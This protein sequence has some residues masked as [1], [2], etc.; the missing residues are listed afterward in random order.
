VA[1]TIPDHVEVLYELA[2]GAPVHMSF[3]ETTGLSRGN[4][5]WIFGSKGTIHVD[6]ANRIFVG[7]VGD[8]E[9]AEHPNPPEGQYRHRV[10]EEFI[11][12]IRG[13][14]PVS[15]NTFEIGVRY[16]EWTEAVHRSANQGA[17][18]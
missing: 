12:A 2:N 10:E 15:M 1:A 11:N 13:I 17:G 8:R 18:V 9:L 14:E 5:T 16:M 6:N 4:D 3:S 7:R